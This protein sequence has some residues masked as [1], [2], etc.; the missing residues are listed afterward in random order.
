MTASNMLI[1]LYIIDLLHRVINVAF[2]HT[3]Q[4]NTG[5]GLEVRMSTP[6]CVLGKKKGLG[7]LQGTKAFMPIS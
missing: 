2:G 1:S 7:W 4:K 3:F 5:H 6:I